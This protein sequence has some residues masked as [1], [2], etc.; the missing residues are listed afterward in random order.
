MID[1]VRM[2]YVEGV[3]HW[4]LIFLV[5]P[6]NEMFIIKV[7]RTFGLESSKFGVEIS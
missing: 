5:N 4:L 6:K 3:L 2:F 1:E 7:K